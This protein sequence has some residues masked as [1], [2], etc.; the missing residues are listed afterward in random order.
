MLTFAHPFFSADI[1]KKCAPVAL[2]LIAE[3][4]SAPEKGNEWKLGF[5]KSPT[6]E[7]Q[8]EAWSE[9]KNVS[10]SDSR[11]QCVQRSVAC[12]SVVGLVTRSLS[13]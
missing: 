12:H 11:K 3:E 10:S 8:G 6:L 4:G 2:H 7:V 5:P 13:S 1:L 9:D